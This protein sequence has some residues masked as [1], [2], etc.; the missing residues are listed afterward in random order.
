M[1]KKG[2][3]ENIMIGTLPLPEVTIR[4]REN[5]LYELDTSRVAKDIIVNVDTGVM[6]LP[7]CD[8]RNSTIKLFQGDRIRGTFYAEMVSKHKVPKIQ[9]VYKLNPKTVKELEMIRQKR[10]GTVKEP[11][12]EEAAKL[13]PKS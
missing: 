7:D 6:I 10:N 4:D 3:E 8:G 13:L 1:P 5:E 2:D 12:M 11:W 9:F